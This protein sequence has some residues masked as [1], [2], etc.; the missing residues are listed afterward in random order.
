MKRLIYKKWDGSQQPFS[1]KRKEIVDT[2]MDNIMKG[3]SPNMSLAQML[4]DG[5]PLHGM[6]FRVMGLEE[7]F[8]ELQK[9]KR[10]LFEMYNLEK[11][12]DKPMEDMK[13]LLAEEAMTRKQNSE[14]PSPSYDELPP[15]LLE[16]IKQLKEYDF[17]SKDSRDIFDQLAMRKKDIFDL[18]EFY[19]R[20]SQYFKGNES[21]DFDQAVELMRLF[22]SIDHARQQILT[23]QF[24][25]I[26]V[27]TLQE[28]LGETAEQSFN[29]LL[30]L[31][32][33]LSEDGIIQVDN[34]GFTMTPRG[35]KAL[36]Q[37]AFGKTFH[38]LKKDFQNHPHK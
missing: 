32:E 22:E 19:S 38:H 15:G 1:L 33:V 5:F 11:A 26:D 35:I 27:E 7:M 18:Y 37:V 24:P 2:F 9:Q 6:D 23:G 34:S 36:G 31:P 8:E 21:V 25:S 29:I 4:W 12:F 30:Q 20:Y 14:I 3:M 17:I 13:Y 16:K 28:L 10:D